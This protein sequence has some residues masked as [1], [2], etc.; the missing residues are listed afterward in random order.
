MGIFIFP[1]VN[2]SSCPYMPCCL[3]VYM[4]MSLTLLSDPSQTDSTL[5]YIIYR[6]KQHYCVHILKFNEKQK[7]NNYQHKMFITT[8]LQM[9]DPSFLFSEIPLSN[10]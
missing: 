3:S 6:G 5:C 4:M 2:A 10:N 8:C 1:Y 9:V 7:K